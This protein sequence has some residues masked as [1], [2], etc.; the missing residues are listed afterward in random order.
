M[1]SE[2]RHF[3]DERSM[4]EPERSQRAASLTVPVRPLTRFRRQLR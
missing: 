2:T 4:S 3:F 1:A